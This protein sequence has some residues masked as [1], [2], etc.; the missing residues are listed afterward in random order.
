MLKTFLRQISIILSFS[1]NRNFKLNKKKNRY[2]QNYI[3]K[4]IRKIYKKNPRLLTHKNLSSEIVQ[5]IREKKLEIF[6]RNNFIQNI[7]FIHN[8][9]FIYS[10]LKELKKD[11]NWKLWKKLIKDNSVGNP[12]WYF[13]YHESTG[14]RIRQV[15]II[16]K[17][18]ELNPTI[19]LT[20]LK[21]IIEIGGGYGCMTDIFFKI[22]KKI[23]YTIYDMYEVNLLQYYYL[24]MNNHNPKLNSYKNKINLINRLNDLKKFKNNNLLIANWSLSE[25]PLNFRKKF[26]STIKNS[27]YTIISFQDNFEN[28]NNYKFFT[29]QIKKLGSKYISKIDTFNHYNNSF[30]N[31]NKHYILTICRK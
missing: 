8:R 19:K 28:I 14:N 6:L 23:N 2:I 13:L 5:I 16:K 25:F 12:I 29:R 15:Y 30:L 27:D 21:K 1:I 22:N 17:F 3:S 24:K 7:F 31:K 26:F 18:L 20:N 4:Q 11:A 10:E 9:F